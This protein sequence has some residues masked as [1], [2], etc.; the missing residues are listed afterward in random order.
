LIPTLADKLQNNS[1]VICSLDKINIVVPVMPGDYHLMNQKYGL[2]APMFH[3]N[4]VNPIF[5][6]SQITLNIGDNILLGNSASYSNN[7]LESID[8]LSEMDLGNRHVIIPLSYGDKKYGEYIN[9]YAKKKLEDK[10]ICL[11]EFVPLEDYFKLLESCP[12]VIMNHLRQ[13]AVGNI[14]PMLAKGSHVYLQLKSSLYQF[15]KEN[16][17]VV[18]SIDEVK[19]IREL[20][21]EEKIKNAKLCV[22]FFGKKTQ[23]RKVETLLKTV[24]TDR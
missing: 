17:F 12:I 18:S 5:D 23:H 20:T 19:S 22:T 7:H 16:G 3:L 10:V 2:K 9:S 14:V 11:M 8:L 1:E 13:Q 24:L 15:L 21:N 6:E 4:Y